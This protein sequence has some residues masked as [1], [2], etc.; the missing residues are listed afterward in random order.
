MIAAQV[1]EYIEKEM[2]RQKITGVALGIFRNGEILHARGYGYSNVEHEVPVKLE[3]IF[4]SG[5]V[6]KQFTAMAIM[7]LI[8]QGRLQLDERI[9]RYFT[10]APAEWRNITVRHLLTH[11]SGMGDYPSDFDFRADYTDEAL[12]RVIKAIPL[13]FQPGDRYDYSNFGYAMLGF[14]IRR[15]TG[16]FYGDFLQQ[17][18]FGPLH[19]TTARVMS[20]ADIVKNRA[21]GYLL[22]DGELKNQ[23]WVSPSLNTQADGSLYLTLLDMVKWDAGLYGRQLLR[24]QSSYDAMWSPMVLNTQ[25]TFPYGFGWQLNEAVNGMRVVSHGGSWQGFRSKIIRVPEDQLSVV[26]FLNLNHR[27]LSDL[28]QRVLEM[29]NSQLA[30]KLESEP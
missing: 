14:L 22:V 11:T 5:S 3:T 6:G 9:N 29:Y 2:Q 8:E 10:D 20:E 13:N 30:L 25:Q 24:N 17:V 15:V 23:Q 18:V 28:A 4:Q 26:V 1:D 7:I 21:S 12:Y 16:L 27:G 19:M